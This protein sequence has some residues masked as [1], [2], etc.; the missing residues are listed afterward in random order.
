[1]WGARGP[2]AVGLTRRYPGSGAELVVRSGDS[3]LLADCSLID[4]NCHNPGHLVLPTTTTPAPSI[5]HVP[6]RPQ[7]HPA[8][9]VN[10]RPPGCSLR[11]A[12]RCPAEVAILA[13]SIP[14]PSLSY[15][16]AIGHLTDF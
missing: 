13:A 8:L 3:P 4:P 6:F 16:K 2:W 12:S 10:S 1:M 11:V 5:L 14:T 7:P 9:C 15:R